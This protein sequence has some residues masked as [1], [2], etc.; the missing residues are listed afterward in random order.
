M[1]VVAEE[2][3]DWFLIE[4][5]GRLYLDVLVEHGAISFSV[6]AELSTEVA[7]AYRRD[8]ASAL[9]C[10]AGEMRRK[11]LVREWQAP[12]LPLGWSARAVAAVHEWQRQRSA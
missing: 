8:G 4:E 3:W 6:T 11:G 7:S 5:D 9:S 10:V 1:K 2:P 12:P